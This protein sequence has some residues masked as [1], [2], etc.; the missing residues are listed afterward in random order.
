MTTA[1]GAEIGD[2]DL[3]F[4]DDD[5]LARLSAAW[6]R[7]GVL[8]VRDQELTPDD[9]VRFAERLGPIVVNR[10]FRPVDGHPSIAE[11]RK[12]PTDTTN[13]GG[14]WHTDHSYDVEPAR[15]SILYAREIP[16]AGGD[17][18]YASTTAAYEALSD[19]FAALLRTLQAF[20][21]NADVFSAEAV[22][23]REVGDRLGNAEAAGQEAVHPVVVAHPE[24][25]R[26]CLYVN[27][28]FTRSIVGWSAEESAM[29]LDFLYAHIA[30]PQ[31]Q[32][33]FRWTEGAVA[34][35]D[36]RSTWH[37]AI[38]DYHGHRRYLHR[39]TLA[40]STLAAA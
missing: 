13:I 19:D 27:P 6:N 14:G 7:Y 21:T 37:Y 8:F 33:R 4:L 15:G 25:G 39:I 24:T 38:N 11:V 18:L 26:P 32:I 2:V 28:G 12:E 29:L 35:W 36:N 31:F 40:G 22:Y 23:A 30:K 1:F 20:H 16:P 9:H 34:L 10:F 3:R 17:T 5:D